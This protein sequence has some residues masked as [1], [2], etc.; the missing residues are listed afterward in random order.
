M[1]ETMSAAR[2]ALN[3]EHPF[4]VR[5][6]Q[7]VELSQADLESLDAI[8]DGEL[9]IRRRHDHVIDGYKFRKLSFVKD[10][11]QASAQRQTSDTQCRAAR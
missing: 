6:S 10:G 11:Y 9:V 7:H 8:I 1:N 4:I 2:K 5:L 3:R